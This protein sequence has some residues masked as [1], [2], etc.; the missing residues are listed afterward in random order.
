[1]GVN[2]VMCYRKDSEKGRLGVLRMGLV[3]VGGED[4]DTGDPVG[5]TLARQISQA[6]GKSAWYRREGEGHPLVSQNAVDLTLETPC[7]ITPST[8][9][10]WHGCI[11][12]RKDCRQDK[13]KSMEL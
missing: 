1:M 5:E 3:V 6:E 7:L 2:S 9:G 13:R 4:E 10:N 11:W 8:L 12:P